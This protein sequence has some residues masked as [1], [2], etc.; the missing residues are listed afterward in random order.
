MLSHGDLARPENCNSKETHS[1]PT[2]EA[3]LGR[4]LCVRGY[5]QARR[6]WRGLGAG[7][8]TRLRVSSHVRGA[9]VRMSP[10]RLGSWDAERT[11]K[12][13]RLHVWDGRARACA[14]SPSGADVRVRTPADPL[15]GS[16]AP[17]AGR[18]LVLRR[19]VS[20]RGRVLSLPDVAPRFSL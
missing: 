14:Q 8:R 16:S 1:A 7:A 2:A 5:A 17:P 18:E 4:G 3:T 11:S 6:D 9:H 20:L 15:V 12:R 19:G 10:R 13:L